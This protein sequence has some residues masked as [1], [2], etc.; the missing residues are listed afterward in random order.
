[1]TH[2]RS[3]DEDVRYAVAPALRRMDGTVAVE[4]SMGLLTDATPRVASA[5][6]QALA[7]M[8]LRPS[9]WEDVALA[10]QYGEVPEGAHP[11]VLELAVRKRADDPG[12]M[13]LLVAMLAG[14]SVSIELKQR[15]ASVLDV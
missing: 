11:A 12:A 3:E 1:M 6:A 8:S 15:V 14:E 13:R 2:A 7:R 9:D 10:L 4:A 5:A